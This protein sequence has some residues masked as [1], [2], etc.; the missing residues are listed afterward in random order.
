MILKRHIKLNGQ[1][2]ACSAP[3]PNKA[4]AQLCLANLPQLV[5]VKHE[6]LVG[7]GVTP[8]I[9]LLQLLLP[10]LIDST[11]QFD[12]GPK[13][14]LEPSKVLCEARRLSVTSI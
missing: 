9:Q 7:Y 13:L 4:K 6:V 2:I 3:A 10:N 11:D 14:H 5:W 1:R 8:D 12:L